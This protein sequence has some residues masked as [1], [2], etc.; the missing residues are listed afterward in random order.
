MLI[1]SISG[2]PNPRDA[3]QSSSMFI[4]LRVNQ[5]NAQQEIVKKSNC[6]QF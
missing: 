5:K 6:H 4:N 1:V 3:H 2:S